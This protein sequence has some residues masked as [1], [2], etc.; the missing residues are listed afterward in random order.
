M[1]HSALLVAQR[2]YREANPSF[3]KCPCCNGSGYE[4]YAAVACEFCEGMGVVDP[5]RVPKRLPFVVCFLR[6]C[7]WI[8]VL[9]LLGVAL[10]YILGGSHE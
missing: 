6:D 7:W 9:F 4:D 1:S 10:G 3:I 5:K 8:F 2:E